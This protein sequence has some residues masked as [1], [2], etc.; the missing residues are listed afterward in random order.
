[1][2]SAPAA[3]SSGLPQPGTGRAR[4]RRREG[5]MTAISGRYG[6]L[7]IAILAALWLA[8]LMLG[9]PASA[10]DLVLLHAFHLPALTR[11]ALAVTRLGNAYVLLPLSLVATIAV[12]LRAGRHPALVYLILIVSGRTLVELQKNAIG[13]ARPD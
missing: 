11:A 7:L 4:R 13:R 6:A 8:M 3:K 1:M 5:G 2:E 9:G 10:A 12:A